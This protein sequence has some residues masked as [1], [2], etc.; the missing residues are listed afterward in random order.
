MLP[1]AFAGRA[2]DAALL[3]DLPAGVDPC[4]ENGE[5]HTFAWDGPD[6]PAP[7]ARCARGEV[8]SATASSSRTCSR[9]ARAT[10]TR[11]AVSGAAL[12][13]GSSPRVSLR[14]RPVRPPRR[15]AS[16]NLSADEVLVEILPPG[17]PRGA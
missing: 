14:P 12:L 2:F 8:V 3:A 17:A 6:V 15:V 13:A 11:S 16:M 1:A 4:G 10:E 5:F 7:G 9:G